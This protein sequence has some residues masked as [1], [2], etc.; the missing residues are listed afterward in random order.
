MKSKHAVWMAMLWVPV[1]L[2][3]ADDKS[4]DSDKATK[5]LEKVD[6]AAK[7]VHAVKYDVVAKGSGG[8][9]TFELKGTYTFSGLEGFQPKKFLAELEV[10]AP[11]ASETKKYTGGSDGENYFVIDHAEKKAY[12][13][14]DPAVMGTRFARVFAAGLMLEFVHDRPFSDEITAESKI[15]KGT[16]TIGGVECFEIDINYRADGGQ[17]ATW[18]FSKKDFLPRKR[19][20]TFRRG[21][22]ESTQEKTITNLVVDP[23]IDDATF[24]M[25]LPEGYALVDD[26]AP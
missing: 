16:K 12:V 24:K 7:A 19:V 8:G 1:V 15:I 9:Q 4:P 17:K 25:K 21:E 14:I 20:D 3:G 5:I 11:G 23:K 6:A 2:A 18:C 26:F 10:T 22:N 13:D